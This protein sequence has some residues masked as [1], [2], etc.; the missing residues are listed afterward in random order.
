MRNKLRRRW[1]DRRQA[2]EG[3]EMP[4]N[5]G[6]TPGGEFK[7]TDVRMQ[8]LSVSQ[9]KLDGRNSRTHSAKQIRQIAK[10]I[11]AFGFT[12]PLL[13]NENA[14]LIAGEGRLK[15][16]QLLGFAKVP[17]IVLAGLSPAR[18]R[19]LAWAAWAFAL[20]RVALRRREL[21]PRRPN[22][23]ASLASVR[24]A[25]RPRRRRDQGLHAAR[26]CRPRHLLRLRHHDPGCRAGRTPRPC[27]GDRASFCRR[28]HPALAGLYPPRRT[29]RRERLELR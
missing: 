10:S 27:A 7:A 9:I 13:V 22:G 3:A 23:G 28:R 16:A 18:Q 29:P 15:A 4:E 8:A 2:S 25:G 24:Q 21:L 26:R 14:K 20:E 5:S 12:N 6:C 19:A 17:A 1:R 11:I